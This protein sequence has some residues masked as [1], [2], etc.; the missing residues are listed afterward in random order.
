MP[1]SLLNLRSGEHPHVLCSDELGEPM[2]LLF[3]QF[4]ADY[5]EDEKVAPGASNES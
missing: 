5:Q 1:L 4:D 3:S 2:A